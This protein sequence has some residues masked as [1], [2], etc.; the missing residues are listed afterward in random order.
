MFF[1]PDR[2]RVSWIWHTFSNRN[3]IVWS[4][5]YPVKQEFPINMLYS[6]Q[7]EARCTRGLNRSISSL[8]FFS[9][10]Y[11]SLLSSLLESIFPNWLNL[12]VL[13]D[14]GNQSIN[15]VS[16]DRD[17]KSYNGYWRR[18][19]TRNRNCQVPCRHYVTI[20]CGL[21][22][23]YDKSL[24][25][26]SCDPNLRLW[27]VPWAAEDCMAWANPLTSKVFF[28]PTKAAG[29]N[30]EIFSIARMC[31]P[32]APMNTSSPLP[33]KSKAVH[34]WSCQLVKNF[35]VKFQLAWISLAGPAF[36]QR[37][38]LSTGTAWNVSTRS[39]PNLCFK[40]RAIYQL[41]TPLYKNNW[42]WVQHQLRCRFHELLQFRM[43]EGT[44]HE[45]PIL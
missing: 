37:L 7:S 16:R 13:Q 21:D 30:G 4:P 38:F 35:G 8:S 40:S 19:L 24:W 23:I 29:L 31:F 28:S 45:Y 2:R 39:P 43:L 22:S 3:N 12:P 20:L 36:L 32:T 44:L 25:F 27:V 9:D 5:P 11:H 1:N 34:P 33:G 17:G 14:A 18:H 42:H 6:I 15:N 26:S 10:G 41:T